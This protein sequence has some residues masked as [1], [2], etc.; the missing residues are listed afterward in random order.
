MKGNWKIAGFFCF[1]L[2]FTAVPIMQAQVGLYGGFSAANTNIPNSKWLYGTTFGAYYNAY[3]V[4]LVNVGLDARVSI[5]NGSNVVN[6]LIGPRAEFHLPIIKP[7]VE[8]LV[9]VS[10][11]N[12]GQG[13]ATFG[14]TAFSYGFSAG[15][16]V[17]IL[18]RL[19]WRVVDYQFTRTPNIL[20]GI[21]QDALTTGIVLR[22]PVP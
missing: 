7:Y 5:L 1:L 8:G 21:N 12:G 3:H 11:I 15:A 13:A 10:D 16:D 9:G 17:T 22:L 20:G 14:Q 4:P 18:P 6:G 19:D 2:S